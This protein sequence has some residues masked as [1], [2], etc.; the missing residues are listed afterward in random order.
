MKNTSENFLKTFF[1]SVTKTSH[2]LKKVD[3]NRCSLYV[4]RTCLLSCCFCNSPSFVKRALFYQISLFILLEMKRFTNVPV[5]PF[6]SE[7]GQP[8]FLTDERDKN[9][10]QRQHEQRF[11]RSGASSPLCLFLLVMRSL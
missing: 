6:I 8:L 5:G 9:P 11:E 4:D 7:H 3:Q 1:F 2:K 10:L